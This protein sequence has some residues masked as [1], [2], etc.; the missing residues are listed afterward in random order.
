MSVGALVESISVATE[1]R[2]AAIL[3]SGDLRAGPPITW[4]GTDCI[5]IAA[6]VGNEE[7]QHAGVHTGLGEATGVSVYNAAFEG[8]KT[9]SSD[10]AEAREQADDR[11]C[12]LGARQEAGVGRFPKLFAAFSR[13]AREFCSKYWA[14]KGFIDC[15]KGSDPQGP[16]RC[17]LVRPTI[18]NWPPPTAPAKKMIRDGSHRKSVTLL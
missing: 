9:W 8:A 12:G 5:V 16:R 18:L 4:T 1:G 7:V 3:A 11:A 14:G 15:N 13:R 6:H 2:T 10:V 17:G